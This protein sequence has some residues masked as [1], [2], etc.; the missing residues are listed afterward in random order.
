[1]TG[2]AWLFCLTVGL[3]A[4]LAPALWNHFP[5]VFFDTGGY[6][7]RVQEMTLA[8]GRSFFYGLFL[9]AGSFAWRSFWGAVLAQ[10]FFTLWSIRLLLRCHELPS[11]PLPLAL[12]S[13]GLALST[14]ISWFTSQLM[15]DIFLPLVVLALW[16]LGFRWERLRV[17]ERAGLAAIALLGLLSHMSCLALGIGLCLV[18]LIARF[19]LPR[20]GSCCSARSLPPVALV[21]ASLVLMPIFHWAWLGKATYT[22]GGPV[23]IF[24]RL[25]QDGIAKRWLDEHCPVAGIKLCGL[26]ERLPKSADAFLWSGDSP[27]LDIGGWNGAE[28]ELSHLVKNCFAAYPGAVVWTALQDTFQQ[29]GEVATGDGLDAFHH[30]ARWVFSALSPPVAAQF[31]AAGQQQGLLTQSLFAPL[32][33]VHIPV[34]HLSLLGLMIAIAWGRHSKRYDIACLALFVFLALLGNAFICGALSNPHA[35]YQSRLVWLAPLVFGMTAVSWSQLRVAR[36]RTAEKGK[37]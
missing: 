9:W 24:G 8:P 33:R 5:I 19:A 1:M 36:A 18:I 17:G 20:M 4:L 31:A 2:L 21:C 3:A 7:N 11:G 28:A 6:I 27:F 29:F 12:F 23:F 26:Q 15:P 16:L 37:K 34:A 25:V 30:H 10:S 35:R 13:L 14:G 22:P 32:N